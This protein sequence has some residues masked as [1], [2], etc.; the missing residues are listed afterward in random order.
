MPVTVVPLGVFADRRGALV[1]PLEPGRLH[2]QRN[3][4]LVLTQPRAVRGN[5]FHEHGTEVATVFGPGLVRLRE[6]GR[7]RDVHVPAGEAYQFT[8]PPGVSH[9]FQ[10]T[11]TAPMAIVTFNTHAHDPTAPDLVRDVLIEP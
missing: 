2:A 1:E 6:D 4:H 10:N 3:V 7:L 9:A 5:H 8:L 11:G